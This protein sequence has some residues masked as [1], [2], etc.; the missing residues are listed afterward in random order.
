MA[1]PGDVHWSF[2]AAFQKEEE[3][4]SLS[5]PFRVSSTD[6]GGDPACG[7]GLLSKGLWMGSN[8]CCGTLQPWGVLRKLIKPVQKWAKQGPLLLQVKVQLGTT[9]NSE[10]LSKII[11]VNNSEECDSTLDGGYYVSLLCIALS[12]ACLYSNSG[13]VF[14]EGWVLERKWHLIQVERR[15]ESRAWPSE[16]DCVCDSE[17]QE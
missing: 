4:R 2:H 17:M 3:M 8:Q 16:H 9:S 6:S 15:I 5:Q 13:S 11:K 1:P 7:F 12:S 14:T 10:A